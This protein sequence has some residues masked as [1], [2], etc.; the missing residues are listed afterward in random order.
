LSR[1]KK[2]HFPRICLSA[3]EIKVSNRVAV[4]PLEFDIL[5]V[6][7]KKIKRGHPAAFFFA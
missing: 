2:C 6:E 1:A 5:K 7:G 3:E 4:Y